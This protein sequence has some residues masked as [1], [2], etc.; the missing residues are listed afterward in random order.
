MLMYEK[1]PLDGVY[2]HTHSHTYTNAHTFSR[3]K[4]KFNEA[5]YF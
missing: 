4:K 2:T 3:L 5:L 1:A